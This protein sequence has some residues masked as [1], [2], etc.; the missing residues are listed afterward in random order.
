MSEGEGGGGGLAP[1]PRRGL[2]ADQR[3]LRPGL[4]SALHP[5]GSVPAADL[6]LDLRD[7]GPPGSGLPGLRGRGRGG[8]ICVLHPGKPLECLGLPRDT[9]K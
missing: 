8:D 4:P 2:P 6:S 5:D 1:G 7:P 3:R 9:V